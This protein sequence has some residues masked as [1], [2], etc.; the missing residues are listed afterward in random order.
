[1]ELIT[2]VAF[3][4][5]IFASIKLLDWGISI[6][7]KYISGFDHI[8]PIMAFALIFIGVILLMNY[9]GKSL[10][11]IL[12]MTLLGSLDDLGGAIMGAVK[13]AF[14]ISI[15]IWIYESFAGDFS[16]E[17]VA[18]SYL[19]GPISGLAPGIIRFFSGLY[20]TFME[21]FDHT[22]QQI[23]NGQIST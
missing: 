16:S 22:G 6:L 18:S 19:Y 11:S 21:I 13:W 4:V 8:L 2:L 15:L 9:L 3:F 17:T 14:F 12:D 23:N 20:P 5:A 1:M 10:K 7:Q